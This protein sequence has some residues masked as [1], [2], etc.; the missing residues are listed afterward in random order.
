MLDPKVFIENALSKRIRYVKEDALVLA[1]R[2]AGATGFL[3]G[4]PQNPIFI[5]GASRSGTSLF[6]RM[7]SEHPAV[8]N[9]SE[10]VYIWEP[11][12]KDFNRD[13]VKRAEDVRHED[14]L[15]I[16]N[17]FGLYQRLK[18]KSVF[19]NKC[20]RNSVRIEFIKDIF[21]EARF[22]HLV[23]DGRAVVNSIL[24]IIERED[25]RKVDKFGKFCRPQNWRDIIHKPPIERFAHQWVGI[26]D[27]VNNDSKGIQSSNWV[28][29]KYENL[30]KNPGGVLKSVYEKLG[31]NGN[32]KAL[33]S[34]SRMP[35]SMNFKWKARFNEQEQEALFSI[36]SR[37][38]KNYG[39]E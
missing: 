16:A 27:A 39:Y 12:D 9:L 31:L 24:S 15:R 14:R 34:V 23:R 18:G 36:M 17:T 19:C 13:H 38:L 29:V 5:L 25:F 21:P 22:V 1:A 10:A 8:A 32:Q 2:L 30:C 28:E 33:S 4:Y 11:R 6:N 3:D 7:V 35:A 20:P 26:L 37:W